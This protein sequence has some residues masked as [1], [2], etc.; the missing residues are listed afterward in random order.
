MPALTHGKRGMKPEHLNCFGEPE[1]VIQ[2]PSARLW[3]GYSAIP[4]ASRVFP[5]WREP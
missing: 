1:Q 4:Q 5:L 2:V 3:G